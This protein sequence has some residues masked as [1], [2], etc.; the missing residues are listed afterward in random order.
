MAQSQAINNKNLDIKLVATSAPS[1]ISIG[2]NST[3]ILHVGLYVAKHKGYFKNNNLKLKVLTNQ[4][5]SALELVISGKIDFAFTPSDR[6]ILLRDQGVP[7]I[8]VAAVLQEDPI[9]LAYKGPEKFKNFSSLSHKTWGL[10]GSKIEIKL[11]EYW[12]RTARI[13][14]KRIK[15]QYILNKDLVNGFIRGADFVFM[16]KGWEGLNAVQKGIPLTFISTSRLPVVLTFPQL[17][18]VTRESFAKNHPDEIRRFLK[19]LAEGYYIAQ[20]RPQE[21]AAI[22]MLYAPY[23]NRK[24]VLNSAKYY[25]PLFIKNNPYWGKIETFNW[26]KLVSWMETQGIIQVVRKNKRRGYTNLFLTSDI[27]KDDLWN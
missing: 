27:N 16:R 19:S 25:S 6:V 21:T 5:K 20:E 17:V 12:L 24:L 4:S 13:D 23:S 1:Q 11:T 14:I 9:F 18:V 10:W 7:L 15:R 22:F 26:N 8:A 2:L 3:N